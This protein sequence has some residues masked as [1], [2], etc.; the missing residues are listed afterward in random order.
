VSQAPHIQPVEKCPCGVNLRL[1]CNV[2]HNQIHGVVTCTFCGRLVPQEGKDHDS[3]VYVLGE[4]TDLAR[5][6]KEGK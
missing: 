4:P 2:H 6:A 1:S 3:Y 5:L